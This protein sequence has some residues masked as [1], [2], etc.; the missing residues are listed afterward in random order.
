MKKFLFALLILRGAF[1]S[2]QESSIINFAETINVADLRAH[3]M[4]LTSDSL[5]GRETGTIGNLKAAKYIAS[6]FEKLG[7]PKVGKDNSYFQRM[8]YSN[9][10]WN[11][12]GMSINDHSY[13]HQFNFY[14]LPYQNPVVE[15]GKIEATDVVFL[16]Y[17][18]DDSHYSDYKKT[19]VKG[20]VILIN[21][22]EPMTKDS[23]S[24]ISKSKTPSEWSK[25]EK[26][27]TTA[28]QHGVKAVLL[29]LKWQKTFRQIVAFS[30]EILQAILKFQMGKCRTVF[31]FHPIWQKKLLV[32]ILRGMQKLVK[33]A[34]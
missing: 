8:V 29:T 20:K 34:L 33:N 27:L 21:M 30:V 5:E 16:G 19:N 2:A 6:Q 10:G 11:N 18:I 12:I 13:R 23:M 32:K 9:D 25:I 4:V 14:A 31:L 28:F 1:L 26:K 22:G 17:G 24:F 3:E 7:L 15:G